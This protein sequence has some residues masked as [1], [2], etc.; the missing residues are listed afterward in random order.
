MANKIFL[1]W[2]QLTYN[3]FKFVVALAGISFAVLLMF[4]QLGFRSA[5][6]ESAARL[7]NVL[8][9]DIILVSPQ[10]ISLV[11]YL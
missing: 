10:Y 9:G 6:F 8:Q 4:M 2:L 3:K 11:S 7:H 1:P 5:L